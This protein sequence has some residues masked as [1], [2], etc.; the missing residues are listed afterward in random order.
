MNNFIKFKNTN[1]LV[2]LGIISICFSGISCKRHQ[3]KKT[4][5]EVQNKENKLDSTSVVLVETPTIIPEKIHFLIKETPFEYLKLK[6]KVSFDS[7]GMKQSFP[8]T[9]HIKKDSVIWVS[10]ALGLEAARAVINQDSLF[11]LDRLNKKYYKV[12]FVDLSR[13]FNFEM[14]YHLLE[15]LLIGNLPISLN[16][17]DLYSKKDSY[18]NLSQIRG[19][20]KIENRLDSTSFKLT[21]IL[22]DDEKSEAKMSIIYQDFLT[23]EQAIVPQKINTRVVNLKDKIPQITELN[24]DHSRF[25]FLEKN[26][27][28]PFSIPKSYSLGKLDF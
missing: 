10:I 20:I 25:D 12:S 13:K 4:I 5:V 24:F 28:F 16:A 17:N 7:P 9:I 6:T 18:L 22:A 11:L 1:I 27:G 14:N 3:V 21:N 15:S 8:A 19:S 26:I 23:I 2:Y